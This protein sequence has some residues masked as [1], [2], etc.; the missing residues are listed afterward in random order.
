MD[1]VVDSFVGGEIVVRQA[2]GDFGVL[3]GDVAG[4]DLLVGECEELEPSLMG[5]VLQH[6]IGSEIETALVGVAQDA[7]LRWFDAQQVASDAAE[8]MGARQ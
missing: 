3:G 7:A 1:Q 2:P 8:R 6:E 5:S 4:E